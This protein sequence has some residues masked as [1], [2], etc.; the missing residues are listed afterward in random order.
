MVIMKN[1]VRNF[2][3]LSGITPSTPGPDPEQ[4]SL[5]DTIL[6]PN[7]SPGWRPNAPQR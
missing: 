7:V 1:E 6:P 4:A 5:A 3:S 2:A